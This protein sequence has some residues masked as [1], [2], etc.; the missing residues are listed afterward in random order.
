METEEWR[1]IPSYEGYYEVSSLGRVMSIPRIDIQGRSRGGH[2]MRLQNDD[3]YRRVDLRK[4]GVRRSHFVHVV[5][6]AAFFGP[7]P[8]GLEVCHGNGIGSDNRIE[9]LRY[10]ASLEN[11]RD[12]LVHGKHVNANKDKCPQGH[13]LESPNLKEDQLKKGW[14]T[15]LACNRTASYVYN[16]PEIDFKSMSDLCYEHSST[17]GKLIRLGLY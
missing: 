4:D 6:A 10:G 9:N 13:A 17:P 12:T 1:P 7:K 14:R 2:L 3:G 15:C 11:H 8:E 5:L 16:H